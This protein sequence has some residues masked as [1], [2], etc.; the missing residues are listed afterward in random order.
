MWCTD[1]Y[2]GRILRHIQHPTQEN[3]IE[4]IASLVVGNATAI[5]SEVVFYTHPLSFLLPMY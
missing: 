1:I 4:Y 5:C 2:T 3:G